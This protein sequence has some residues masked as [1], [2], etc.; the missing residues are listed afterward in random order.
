MKYF[1]RFDLYQN[2]SFIC[3]SAG[4]SA[5][6]TN[7]QYNVSYYDGGTI[8]LI[9]NFLKSYVTPVDLNMIMGDPQVI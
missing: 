2:S 1:I 9:D 8:S 5:L 4:V 6:T 7:V 3:G